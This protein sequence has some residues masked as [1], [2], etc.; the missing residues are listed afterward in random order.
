M[1]TLQRP[2]HWR[3]SRY[4]E[5]QQSPLL[6]FE[7]L[8]SQHAVSLFLICVSAPCPSSRFE[9]DPEGPRKHGESAS[10]RLGS[11]GIYGL[12]FSAKRRDPCTPQWTGCRERHLQVHKQENSVF[13]TVF[14]STVFCI[15]LMPPRQRQACL[16][17]AC[18]GIFN[19][20]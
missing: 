2:S 9:S 11:G 17:A 15:L 12:R 19:V 5:V 13:L 20:L 16:E 1:E 6:L 4:T 18:Q 10:V 3:T 14:S 8:S 7:L